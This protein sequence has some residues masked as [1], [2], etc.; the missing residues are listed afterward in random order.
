MSEHVDPLRSRSWDSA[1]TMS[2][3]DTLLEAQATSVEEDGP[4]FSGLLRIF[5]DGSGRRVL[6]AFMPL[7]PR[8]ASLPGDAAVH[9]LSRRSTPLPSLHRIGDSGHSWSNAL[10]TRTTRR[11]CH[12]TPIKIGPP[13]QAFHSTPQQRSQ[14]E[15]RS[16]K[17]S[18][19]TETKMIASL[20]KVLELKYCIVLHRLI[21][22]L[23]NPLCI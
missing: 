20:K 17:Q 10:A 14:Y 11:Y 3:T 22:I 15:R 23:L 2:G 9:R 19:T 5:K 13:N 7:P 1:D 12:G 16:E 6:S 21:G 4:G 8:P 18:K